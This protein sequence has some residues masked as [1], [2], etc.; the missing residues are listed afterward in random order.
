MGLVVGSIH[1]VW[2][3]RGGDKLRRDVISDLEGLQGDV[4]PY[5]SDEVLGTCSSEV[6]ALSR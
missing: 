5:T 3:R 2:V 1:N 6:S 4:R